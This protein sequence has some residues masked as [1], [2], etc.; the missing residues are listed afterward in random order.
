MGDNMKFDG[1]VFTLIVISMHVLLSVSSL[2]FKLPV[3]RIAEGS[4]IWPEYR[5]HSIIFAC[6]SLACMFAMLLEMRNSW[7]PMYGVN[8]VI[9]LAT[10]AAADFASWWVD[11]EGRSSTI[12]DLSAPPALRFFFSV[13]QFHGTVGCLVGFRFF[14][15][16]FF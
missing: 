6:R 1:S 9:V 4:R 16:Q 8:V 7:E 3:R 15:T 13:M 10:N 14:S 12:R 2:I 11:P 5:L